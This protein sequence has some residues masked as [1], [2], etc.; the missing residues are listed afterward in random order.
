MKPMTMT[1]S[2]KMILNQTYDELVPLLLK[3]WHFQL[4]VSINELNPLMASIEAQINTP[5]SR[6][7][8]T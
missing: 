6:M 2:F 4:G 7:R 1:S 3:H 5:S 8:Q